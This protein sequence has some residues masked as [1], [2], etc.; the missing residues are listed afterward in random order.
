M[1]IKKVVKMSAAPKKSDPGKGMKG[2]VKGVMNAGKVVKRVKQGSKP[3]M[4]KR[5]K[6]GPVRP[7][8]ETVK[9]VKMDSKPIN[10]SYKMSASE[11]AKKY[12]QAEINKFTKKKP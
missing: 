4:E 12:T 1:A 6:E 5:V 11:S 2:V 9:R 7:I 8:G 3:L 10:N